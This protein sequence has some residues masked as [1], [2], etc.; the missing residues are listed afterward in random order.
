MNQNGQNNQL[1]IARAALS[2]YQ[3]KV[4]TDFKP[5]E[6]LIEDCLDKALVG[7]SEELPME[8]CDRVVAVALH[9]NVEEEIAKLTAQIQQEVS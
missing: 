4:A 8:F 7:Q 3:A 6:R 9:E 2:L 1:L 5:G